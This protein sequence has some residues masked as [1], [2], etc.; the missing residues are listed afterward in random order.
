MA[1]AITPTSS[2]RAVNLL[3]TRFL[4]WFLGIIYLFEEEKRNAIF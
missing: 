2:V 3:K 1:N 4:F